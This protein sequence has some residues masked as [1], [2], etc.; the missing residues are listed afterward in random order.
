LRRNGIRSV[1]TYTVNY[2][3]GMSDIHIDLM[4]VRN[5][6]SPIE[7]V[8]NFDLT[9]CQIWFDGEAVYA[10]HP[11]HIETRNGLLQRDYVETYLSGNRF[12]KNRIEKYIRRGFNIQ[13]DHAPDPSTL[14]E[15]ALTTSPPHNRHSYIRRKVTCFPDSSEEEALTHSV[16]R[17]LLQK[18]HLR[19]RHGEDVHYVFAIPCYHRDNKVFSGNDSLKWSSSGVRHIERQQPFPHLRNTLLPYEGYDSDDEESMIAY[20]KDPSTEWSDTDYQKDVTYLYVNSLSVYDNVM[21]TA[22]YL[23]HTGD[24]ADMEDKMGELEDALYKLQ[25]VVPTHTTLYDLYSSMARKIKDRKLMYNSSSYLTTLQ[26]MYQKYNMWRKVIESMLPQGE[27]MF[28]RKGPLLLLHQHDTSQ[29]ITPESLKE[30]IEK[31]KNGS[32]DKLKTCFVPGC[33]KKITLVEQ[34]CVMTANPFKHLLPENKSEQAGGK[35]KHRLNRLKRTFR[36][37]AK[38]HFSTRFSVSLKQSKSL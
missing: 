26:G 12:L 32:E 31:T 16:R 2:P 22:I 5:H 37:A 21:N 3:G 13:F 7:V 28:G 25:S 10:S 24:V 30:Y 35:R 4:S 11:Q 15:R 29:G 23:L 14:I 17:A 1:K 20:Q 36:Q 6:R 34:E 18:F 33:D 38:G 8:T 9:F 19:K 27:D